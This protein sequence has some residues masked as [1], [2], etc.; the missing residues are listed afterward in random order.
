[1]L[2]F[3]D[4]LHITALQF[5]YT[6]YSLVYDSDINKASQIRGK[7]LDAAADEKMYIGGAHIKFPGIGT[8]VKKG[9]GYLF[10]P[11]K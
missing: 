11:V 2:L 4:L 10:K 7:T 5:P 8:V 3:G 1:M 6:G 9:N